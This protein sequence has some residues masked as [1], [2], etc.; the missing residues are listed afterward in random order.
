MKLRAAA[1]VPPLVKYSPVKNV[2][3]VQMEGPEANDFRYGR[4]GSQWGLAIAATNITLD[5]QPVVR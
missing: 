3:V 2:H 4:L 1:P 5:A